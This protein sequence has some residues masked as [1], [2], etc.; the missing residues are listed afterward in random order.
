MVTSSLDQLWTQ[1]RDL[2]E[3]AA[4]GRLRV[5]QAIELAGAVL[6]LEPA[7]EEAVG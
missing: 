3:A 2:L 4:E 5:S 6:S 7:R 1:A